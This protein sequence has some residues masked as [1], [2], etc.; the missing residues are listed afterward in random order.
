MK[1]ETPSKMDTQEFEFPKT[2]FSRDI[3]TKVI[4]LI[5][6]QALTKVKGVGAL[7][8]HVLGSFFGREGERVKGISVEQDSKNHSVHVKVEIKVEYG[9]SL[10][11]KA[12]EVQVKLVEEIT[13]LTGLHVASV[14]VVIKGLILDK[15]ENGEEKPT[16]FP[17][18]LDVQAEE[19]TFE[20]SPVFS[21]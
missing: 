6:L 5:I 16:S 17:A 12:E 4:Q 3:E 8:G 20:E 10:P 13:S 7:E 14:H 21:I 1:K 19:S 9:L 11:A 2:T 18:I 15:N